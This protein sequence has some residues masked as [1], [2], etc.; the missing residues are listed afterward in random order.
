MAASARST[1][2]VEAGTAGTTVAA[3]GTAGTEAGTRDL[4]GGSNPA[5]VIYA[6]KTFMDANPNTMQAVARIKATL[7]RNQGLD[8]D[9]LRARLEAD[10]VEHAGGRLGGARLRVA[11]PGREGRALADDGA[12]ALDVK[13]ADR[14]EAVAEG[15]GG[16]HDGVAQ[17]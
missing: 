11:G 2:S 13:Y 10:G 12:Q 6:K 3:A 15:A 7:L 16:G 8:A 17:G 9:S 4:F 1:G 14:L 5:A